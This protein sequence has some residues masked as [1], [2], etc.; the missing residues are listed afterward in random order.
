MTC[1]NSDLVNLLNHSVGLPRHDVCAQCD[2]CNLNNDL[3]V[4]LDT[5]AHCSRDADRIVW[6]T[7]CGEGASCS[8]VQPYFNDTNSQSLSAN[9]S[10][11]KLTSSNLTKPCQNFYNR[12]DTISI[13]VTDKKIK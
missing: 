13:D 8:T 10:E 5:S 12:R 4:K 6:G 2:S 9:C 1:K 7:C 3:A 11:P